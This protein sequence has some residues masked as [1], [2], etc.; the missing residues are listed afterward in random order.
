MKLTVLLA[1]SIVATMLVCPAAAEPN[2]KPIGLSIEVDT[3][4]VF[5]GKVNKVLVTKVSPASQASAAGVAAGDEV[6]Q[7]HGKVVPGAEARSLKPQMEFIPG[8]PK[9]IAFKRVN[10]SVYE[11]TF[12]KFAS[13][14]Q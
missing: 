7:V 9:R 12:T 11:V 3:D 6:I 10:G 5:G 4:S 1:A 2:S 8:Q 14:A 13:L